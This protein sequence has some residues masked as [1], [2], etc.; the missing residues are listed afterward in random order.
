[1]M[2][3]TDACLIVPDWPAPP[4]VH[5]V[6]TTRLGGVSQAPYD[7]LNLG[8]HVG[9]NPLHVA[10]NRQRLSN[11]LPSEPVWM[12]QVHGT[13]VQDAAL[14]SCVPQADAA[15]ARHVDTVC[16]VMTADCLPVLLCDQAGTVVAAAHAGWRGLS[17]GVIERTVEAM[18]TPAKNLLAWLGPAIGRDAFEVGDDVYQ[19]F[20]NHDAQAA[21]AFAAT[22][23]GKWLAD[24]YLLARQRLFALGV[25]QVY[26]G[27]YCTF[28]DASRFFSYRRDGACGRMASMIWLG[29]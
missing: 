20:V 19:I 25:T 21:A 16:T 2:K 27:E 22:E 12:E 13:I 23:N 1:M 9:D 6:Q 17:Q 15:V 11:I 18:H 7:S 24:I 8:T 28:H 5:V 3:L 14:A 10:A 4:N 26:G 29:R